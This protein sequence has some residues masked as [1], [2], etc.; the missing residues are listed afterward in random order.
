VTEALD[1][2]SIESLISRADAAL[3]DAKHLGRNCVVS[4]EEDSD[5]T[6]VPMES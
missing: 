2:D 3:Y 1:R 6:S 5:W 4:R